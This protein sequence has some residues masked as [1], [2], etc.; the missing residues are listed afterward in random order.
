MEKV[1]MMTAV[2]CGIKRKQTNS[3]KITVKAD[4]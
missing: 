4:D 2:I 1:A 3:I